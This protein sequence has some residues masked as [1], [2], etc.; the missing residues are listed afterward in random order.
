MNHEARRPLEVG[1]R[2][3]RPQGKSHGSLGAEKLMLAASC[4]FS[5]CLEQVLS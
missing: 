5:P 2:R 4:L 3:G 1:I